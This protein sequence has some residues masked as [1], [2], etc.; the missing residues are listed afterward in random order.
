MGEAVAR[1]RP[2]RPPRVLTLVRDPDPEEVGAAIDWSGWYLFEEDDVGQSPEQDDVV[3]ELASALCEHLLPTG[4]P[5]VRVGRDA[6]FAWIRD[7]PNVR[8]SP[9]VYVLDD[10]PPPP[11]P[12]MWETWRAGHRAPRFALEVVSDDWREDYEESPAKYALLG[13]TEL[14]I[15]DPPAARGAV[16]APRV[17]ITVYRREDDGSFVRTY[18]GDGP[19]RLESIGAWAVAR[20]EGGVGWLRLARD[21][22]GND[23]VPTA[24]ERAEREARRAE[25]EA[26]RAER[27]AQRAE[28][29][30][31]RAEQAAQRAERL[32]ERLRALG[33]DPDEG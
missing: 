1:R 17:P 19:A 5:S 26:Q 27:E 4:D 30:A 6:F 13:A 3:N 21:A 20:P 32:R 28:R 23:I 15:F 22:E 14:V 24:S 7:E 12:K 29:E 8:V 16:R 11:W 31:Q 9:D 2:M 33:I 25:Q 10:P 18:A